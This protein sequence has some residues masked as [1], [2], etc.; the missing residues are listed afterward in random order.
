MVSYEE[1]LKITSELLCRRMDTVKDIRPSDHIQR[2]LGLDS[3]AVMEFAA[4]VENRFEINIPTEL[5]EVL[6]TVDDVSRA[7]VKLVAAQHP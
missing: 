6:S 7:I 5:L 4:D 3:L 2:D 1:S